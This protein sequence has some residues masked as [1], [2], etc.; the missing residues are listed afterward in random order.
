M[1]IMS[2]LYSKQTITF[3]MHVKSF[4]KSAEIQ[5][6]VVRGQ[7]MSMDIEQYVGR[8]LVNHYGQYWLLEY[9][10]LN[11]FVRCTMSL[12]TATLS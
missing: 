5:A 2:N 7:L 3:E 8:S 12:T 11:L 6:F 10:K 1:Q 4:C 9:D